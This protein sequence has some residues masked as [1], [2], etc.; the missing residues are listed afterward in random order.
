[1]ADSLLLDMDGVLLVGKGTDPAVYREAAGR[2]LFDL[3]VVDPPADAVA[4]LGRPPYDDETAAACDRLGVP[5]DA[6]WAA[7]ERHA[8]LLTNRRVRSGERAVHDDVGAVRTLAAELPVGVASNNRRATVEFVADSLF[9]G[10]LAV[11][12]GREPTLP[13]YRTR[14]KPEPDILRRALPA[15]PDDPLYVGDRR[16]DVVAARRADVDAAFVRRPHNRDIVLDPEPDLV[17][18]DLGELRAA[19]EVDADGD[20]DPGPDPA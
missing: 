20:A 8:S 14:R 19:L 4:T 5:T 17:V 1:M 16:K 7:R 9:D 15:L 18:E 10:D 3:G 11:A 12:V 13:D 2:A 6:F